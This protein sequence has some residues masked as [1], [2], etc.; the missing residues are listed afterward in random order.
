MKNIKNKHIQTQII[1]P[2]RGGFSDI[3]IRLFVLVSLVLI[4]LLAPFF[5]FLWSSATVLMFAIFLANKRSIFE[6]DDIMSILLYRQG[7][8]RLYN[9]GLNAEHYESRIKHYEDKYEKAKLAKTQ[10]GSKQLNANE[11]KHET[12]KVRLKLVSIR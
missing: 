2:S 8:D 4:L 3:R 11:Q 7:M 12:P 1:S 10:T 5:G 9:Y 6:Q